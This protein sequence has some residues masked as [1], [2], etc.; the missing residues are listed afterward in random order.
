MILLPASKAYWKD[1]L[2]PAAYTNVGDYIGREP[3]PT[4]FLSLLSGPINDDGE[5][6]NDV[7][8]KDKSYS[9]Q[10][11]TSSAKLEGRSGRL[12]RNET[13]KPENPSGT[14][15]RSSPEYH[16]EYLVRRNLEHILSVCSIPL[17]RPKL[18]SDSF[19]HDSRVPVALTCGDMSFHR[20]TASSS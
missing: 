20:I 10:G 8:D 9:I 14:P 17:R 6:H 15:E 4:M 2:I 16:I 13:M 12:E 7:N 1:F 11:A 3:R 19:V 5:H 18:E